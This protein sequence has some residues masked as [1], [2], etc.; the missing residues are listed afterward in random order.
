[1]RRG[2]YCT[3]AGPPPWSC[4]GLPQ[5]LY[6]IGE[7]RVADAATRARLDKARPK[8]DAPFSERVLFVA[9]LE[10]V[11]AKSAAAQQRRTLSSERPA[12]WSR[13]K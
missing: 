2:S 6:A 5:P 4:G 12:A 8:P 9:L 1:M 7:F 11:G 13:P 3:R 10:D